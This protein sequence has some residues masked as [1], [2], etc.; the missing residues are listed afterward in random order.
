MVRLSTRQ[1]NQSLSRNLLTGIKEPTEVSAQVQAGGKIRVRRS[2]FDR[3]MER[4]QVKR[5]DVDRIVEEIVSSVT[6]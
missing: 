1:A 3:W 6:R 4:Q 5:L 2:E